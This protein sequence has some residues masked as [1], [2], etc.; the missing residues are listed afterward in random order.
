[1]ARI[2][3]TGP[4]TNDVREIAEYIALE[5]PV[6]ARAL[7]QRIE[8]RCPIGTPSKQRVICAGD[9]GIKYPPV[10]RTALSDLLQN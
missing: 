10:G 1:M 3:W 9:G 6:A 8:P 5:N 7:A 2:I 4:A